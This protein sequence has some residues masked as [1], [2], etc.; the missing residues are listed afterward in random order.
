MNIMTQAQTFIT[1][2]ARQTPLLMETDVLSL[3]V[4]PPAR[5]RRSLPPQGK[6]V[7]M[8]ERFGSLGGNLTLGLNTKPSGH[9]S[10]AC[11]SRSESRTRRGRRRRRLHGGGQDRRREDCIALRP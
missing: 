5:S 7:V 10:A 9:S 11:R 2:P 1:E 8:I 6:R 3:A 4:A